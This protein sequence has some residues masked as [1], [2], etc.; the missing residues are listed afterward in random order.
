M[1]LGI[2]GMPDVLLLGALAGLAEIVPVLGATLA[3][4][5]IFLSGLTVDLGRGLVGVVIYL[6]IN[7]LLGAFVTPRIMGR[8][9]KLHPFVVMVSV[10]AGAQLLGPPG[11]ILALPAAAVLQ[12]L[13]E[14]AAAEHRVP[15]STRKP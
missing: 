2:A 9:L 5:V 12:A 13:V 4:I 7:W 3:V 1:A 15:H 6:T 8:E 10:L 14:D 11:A